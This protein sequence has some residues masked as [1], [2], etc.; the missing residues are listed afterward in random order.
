[1]ITHTLATT[2]QL[3]YAWCWV[4][5]ARHEDIIHASSLSMLFVH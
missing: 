3:N 1:M 2:H 4:Y 5:V